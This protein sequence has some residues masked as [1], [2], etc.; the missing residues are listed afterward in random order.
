[1]GIM[2]RKRRPRIR[3]TFDHEHPV[4]RVIRSLVPQDSEISEEARER[5][6]VRLFALQRRMAQSQ[7]PRYDSGVKTR[8]IPAVA[9]L[10]VAA[11]I[12]AVLLP[13]MLTGKKTTTLKLYAR[14]ESPTGKVKIK[15]PAGKWEIAENGEQVGEGTKI[16]TSDGAL[17]S[18]VFPDG[19]RMRV[20]DGSGAALDHI[21]KKS[22][23]VK[24][25]SGSTYHRVHAGTHYVVSRG[26][27]DALA[28][29]T[30]FSV[31]SRKPGHLEILSV[32]N[33]VDVSIGS[34]QPIEVTEGEVM[35][36][37]TT[38][39]QH[40]AKKAVS[41]ERLADERLRASVESDA[42]E[43]YST[44]VYEKL[45][46]PLETKEEPTQSAPATSVSFS[47]GGT[48]SDKSV[49]LQWKPLGTTVYEALVLLRSEQ[50]EPKYPDDEIARY[51]DT[52][53]I[54]ADD[55]GVEAGKTY[56]YRLAALDV[57][58]AV[59]AYSNSVV[60]SVPVTVSEPEAASVSLTAAAVTGDAVVKLGWS[61]SGATQFSGFVVERVVEKA[62]SGSETPAGT[63]TTRT[64][65]STNVYFTMLDKSV[66]AGYTY[67][68]RVGLVVDGWV[69]VYSAPVTV[70]VPKP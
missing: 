21:S 28:S 29:D 5:M 22:V 55:D 50:S 33:Q 7:S 3:D 69:M 65:D 17:V 18:V 64:I 11:I 4:A 43:G 2:H 68:Y 12:A 52:S 37:S 41:R 6:M 40:A 51:T 25:I 16:Y 24:H 13:V 62:P 70:E 42:K 26:D 61:V 45:D 35:V 32:E 31:D 57:S 15:K 8:L 30:A 58:G 66:A 47:L 9:V 49:S 67:T 1:M 44:G 38:K 59:A 39:G 14:L 19:S 53:I 60:I 63:T 56:Q 23:T 46:V 36:V 27:V 34:H 48:A 10:V 20:T 54:S